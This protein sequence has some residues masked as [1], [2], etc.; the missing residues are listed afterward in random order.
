MV[1]S[2]R[3][4]GIKVNK[5]IETSIQSCVELFKKA[6]KEGSIKIVGGELGH[7]FYRDPRIVSALN[8]A[9][10]R[11][12][13]IEVIYGPEMDPVT[14]ELMRKLWEEGKLNLWCLKERYPNHFMVVDDKFVSVEDFHL[15]NQDKRESLSYR[16]SWLGKDLAIEFLQLKTQ[17]ELYS[18]SA[19]LAHL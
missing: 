1:V 3:L 17:A 13:S 15:P 5:D 18:P 2:E 10:D 6:Q 12:V 9:M 11:N 4:F 8:E 7:E 14:E 16:T 19:N